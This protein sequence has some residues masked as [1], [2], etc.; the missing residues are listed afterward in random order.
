MGSPVPHNQIRRILLHCT[1]EIPIHKV[2][3]WK[4]WPQWSVMIG[5][6]KAQKLVHRGFFDFP[7]TTGLSFSP[8]ALAA[9]S[10]V[11][12]SLEFFPPLQESLFG[13]IDLIWA[14]D[15]ADSPFAKRSTT[16]TRSSSDRIFCF[17]LD[18]FA[19]LSNVT[20]V[21]AH[22]SLFICASVHPGH[23]SHVFYEIS[24]QDLCKKMCC[25]LSDG[26]LSGKF[27]LPW[28]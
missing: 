10:T 4:A 16:F 24:L 11:I 27:K 7:I 25:R 22:I 26:R 1:S 20:V 17:R 9:S 18:I 23:S 3:I 12:L 8:V 21:T 15:L 13:T 6:A 28:S 14:T 2:G 19:A 5:L